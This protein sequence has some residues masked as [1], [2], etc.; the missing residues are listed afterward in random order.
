MI[1]VDTPITPL[2]LQMFIDT[3]KLNAGTNLLR[4]K[5]LIALKNDPDRPVVIHGVQHLIHPID[6][7]ESWP[8][9]DR[10]TKIVLIGKNLDVSVFRQV[11]AG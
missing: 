11:L 8:S 1:T 5:G 6:Q 4:L 9:D 2:Q 7:L 3:L 10:R